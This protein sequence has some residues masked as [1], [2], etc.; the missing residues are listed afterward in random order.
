MRADGRRT[1]NIHVEQYILAGAQLAENFALQRAIAV[2]VDRGMLEEVSGLDPFEERTGIE[3][4]IVH[5]VL[6]T[7]TRFPSGASDGP[8]HVWARRQGAFAKRGLA[9]PRRRRDDNQQRA[10]GGWRRGTRGDWRG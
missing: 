10:G 8:G 5:S 1:L 9:R 6:F 7:R 4:K 3:E 2:A